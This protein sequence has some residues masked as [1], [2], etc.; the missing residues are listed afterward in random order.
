MHNNSLIHSNLT[1]YCIYL[2]QHVACGEM[3]TV[4]ATEDKLL[5][6]GSR[7]LLQS[8]ISCPVGSNHSNNNSKDSSMIEPGTRKHS[9]SMSGSSSISPLPT[10]TQREVRSTSSFPDDGLTLQCEGDN[11]MITPF[12]LQRKSINDTN[13]ALITEGNQ[14]GQFLISLL[15][16]SDVKKHNSNVEAQSN[17]N[18]WK[19]VFLTSH[20]I[21]F[22]NENGVMLDVASSEITKLKVEGIACYGCNL[23]VLT[24]G[25]VAN[26]PTSTTNILDDPGTDIANGVTAGTSSRTPFVMGRRLARQ[27]M[28]RKDSR[29]PRNLSSNCKHTQL[30]TPHTDI[31]DRTI[32]D[33][34]WENQSC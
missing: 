7:P 27:S 24:E 10:L 14:Y 30:C 29:Y 13:R 34:S 22:C 11:R 21:Q 19:K 20:E 9:N 33:Q 5:F 15:E 31:R 32:S 3:S 1:N 12:L 6:W 25:Q 18:D 23:L 8:T 4:V 17:F 26:T 28:F 16:S 2:T